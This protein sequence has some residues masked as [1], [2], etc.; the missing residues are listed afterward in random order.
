M[1]DICQV[2][3]NADILTEMIMDELMQEAMRDM[4]VLSGDVTLDEKNESLL[5]QTAT[6][7]QNI[8][9]RLGEME[10]G[11]QYCKTTGFIGTSHQTAILLGHLE[12][13]PKSLPHMHGY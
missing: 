4:S 13:H 7:L 1:D 11:R 10:V 2:E 3:L 8:I 9:H 12:H 6:D 5:S